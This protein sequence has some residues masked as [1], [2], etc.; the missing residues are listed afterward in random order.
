MYNITMIFTD[1]S[2][3]TVY[4]PAPAGD[5]D[6]GHRAYFAAHD[7]FD[8]LCGQPDAFAGVFINDL[9]ETV[10]AYVNPAHNP[11]R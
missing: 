5:E 2:V 11:A 3:R 9:G 1:G 10:N 6:N 8:A 7:K 4:M